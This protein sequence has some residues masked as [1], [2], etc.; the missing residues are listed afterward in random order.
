MSVVREL[1]SKLFYHERL[2]SMMSDK[3]LPIKNVLLNDIKDMRNVLERA[4]REEKN[5]EQTTS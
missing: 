2:I 3:S 4:K 1:K 5:N